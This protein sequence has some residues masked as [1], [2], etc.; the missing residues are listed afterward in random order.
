M[1]TNDFYLTMAR[2]LRQSSRN[3]LHIAVGSGDAAWDREP[4]AQDRAI[5]A[6]V[7]ETARRVVERVVFLDEDGQ[8][9]R[10]IT[11][12]MRFSVVFGPEE[13]N[14][15]LRECGLF[16]ERS[17]EESGAGTLLSYFAFPRIEKTTGMELERTIN[18]DL[19]PRV[20]ELP[21]FFEVFTAIDPPNNGRRRGREEAER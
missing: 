17:S 15:T 14:G 13:A 5:S 3:P 21:L 8:P 10:S 9:T 20:Q 18:I 6:L 1:L 4:P 12:R 11:Q 2:R 7:N 19:T 16:G